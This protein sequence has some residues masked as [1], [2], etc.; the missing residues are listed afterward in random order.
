MDGR[1][2]PRGFGELSSPSRKCINS[3][4][5]KRQGPLRRRSADGPAFRFRS[6]AMLHLTVARRS[7]SLARRIRVPLG[8]RPSARSRRRSHD[9]PPGR[10]RQARTPEAETLLRFR[11]R[12]PA[13]QADAR[14]SAIRISCDHG[15]RP[16][17]QSF[18]L[19]PS[20]S[21]VSA[22]PHAV[23][24]CPWVKLRA[25]VKSVAIRLAPLRLA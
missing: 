10:P 8:A 18:N 21:L 23:S 24:N 25:A 14:A 20:G 6:K 12:R 16:N 17:S 13:P 5:P 15:S 1:L 11:S 22:L 19:K 3:F 4:S 9:R 2:H 7:P